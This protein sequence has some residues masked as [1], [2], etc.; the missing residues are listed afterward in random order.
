ME[1]VEMA[2]GNAEGA[3][4]QGAGSFALKAIL[5]CEKW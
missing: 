2:T 3:K 1:D 5:E 4:E